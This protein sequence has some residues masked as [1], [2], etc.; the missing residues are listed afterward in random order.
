MNFIFFMRNIILAFFLFFISVQAQCQT[1]EAVHQA[2][3]SDSTV[4]RSVTITKVDSLPPPDATES[5]INFCKVTGWPQ[6]LTPTAPKGFTV[7]KFAGDLKNPRNVYVLPNGDV[8]VAEASIVHTGLKKLEDKVSGKAQA[9]S[10]TESANRITLFRDSNKDGKPELREVFLSGLNQ[11]YG[12]LLLNNSFYVANTDGVWV[13]PYQKGQTKI[14]AKGKKIMDIMPGGYNNHWTRNI[15]ASPDKKHIFVSVGSG[16]NV[17]EH[18]MENEKGRA[19]I[20]IIKL[21]GKG[22]EVYAYGLRNPTGMAVNPTTQILW[23]SVNERDELGDNLVP[24]YL[25]H[26][27]KG[28]FYGWPYSYYGNH[29]DPRIKEKDQRPDLVAK[30]IMP[31]LD[32]GSHTASLGLAFY[33]GKSFPKKY[34]NGAFIGQHGSWNRAEF[35]GY[36]VAFVPF[37]DGKPCGK[38]ED[39]L[40]GFMPDKSK[41]EAHGRPVNIAVDTDGSL[42]VADDAGNTVWR[43]SY[44]K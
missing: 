38:P 30:A 2:T 15:I 32:L 31:D 28:G 44:K 42:L 41:G 5:V 16:S 43:V 18:G 4:K 7:V 27:K 37:K 1:K 29:L 14:T 13:Y 39:F 34:H 35:V 36:R 9:E 11:P 23:T 10:V 19:N 6:G 8:L 24:D 21:D 3:T 22:E 33:H 17:A 20:L 26:V 12:M 25:T 40:T